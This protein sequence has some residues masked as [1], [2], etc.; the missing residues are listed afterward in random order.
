MKPSYCYNDEVKDINDKIEDVE[1]DSNLIFP[2][3][4][5]TKY[6]SLA[7]FVRSAS[8]EVPLV[9]KKVAEHLDENL[10]NETISKANWYLSSTSNV[11]AG[12]ITN[13]FHLRIDPIPKFYRYNPYKIEFLNCT[14]DS[15]KNNGTCIDGTC[16]CNTGRLSS[17]YVF[18]D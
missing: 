6:A 5:Y 18:L 9:F 11:S 15:C 17:Y 1:Y 4:K 3:P 12:K 8:D 10:G 13:W 2:C 16:E 14:I 7:S